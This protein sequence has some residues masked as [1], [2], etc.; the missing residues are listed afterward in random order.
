MNLGVKK[1]PVENYNDDWYASNTVCL[2]VSNRED[3]EPVDT[4]N[5]ATFEPLLRAF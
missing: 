3:C 1:L 5:F 2:A 4:R